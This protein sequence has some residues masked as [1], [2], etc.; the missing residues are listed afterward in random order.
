VIACSDERFRAGELL[1]I[2]G[3]LLQLDGGCGRSGIVA[4]GDAFYA[5]GANASS[6]YREYKGANDAYQNDVITLIF[7]RLC[8]VGAKQSEAPSAVPLVR[9]DRMQTGT[10]EDIATFRIGRSWLAARASEMVETIDGSNI[11]PLPRMPAGMVGCV[12]YHGSTLSVLDLAK[13]VGQPGETTTGNRPS[14][15]IV[16]M[17]LPDDTRFGLLVDDLG[18]IVEVLTNR[19]APLPQMMTRQEAF[20]DTVI[21]YG[22]ADDSGLLVVLSAE[23]LYGSLSVGSL[24]SRAAA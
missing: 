14:G 20:A 19:L 8:G 18:E 15:Q 16:V 4:L 11:V 9:S 21:A 2:D 23:R 3:S 17:T 6:G 7:T 22:D 10:K 13:A 1:P 24:S 5:V 12:M